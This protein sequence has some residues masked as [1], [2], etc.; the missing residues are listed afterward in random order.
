[1]S[2]LGKIIAMIHGTVVNIKAS[3]RVLWT[4]KYYNMIN[5]IFL[6]PTLVHLS[7]QYAIPFV[8]RN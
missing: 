8:I 6:R 2:E 5:Y 3:F 4:R 1:M 7:N